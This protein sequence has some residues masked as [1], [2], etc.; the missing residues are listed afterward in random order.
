MIFKDE[1]KVEREMMPKENLLSLNRPTTGW[2]FVPEQFPFWHG[3]TKRNI[4]NSLRELC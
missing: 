3:E 4:F 2:L 1:V